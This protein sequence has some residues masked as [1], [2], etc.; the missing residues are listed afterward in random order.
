MVFSYF[1]LIAKV[2]FIG[3]IVK[4][5]RLRTTVVDLCMVVNLNFCLDRQI[6]CKELVLP[7]WVNYEYFSEK[8]IFSNFVG[9]VVHC[10]LGASECSGLQ[11]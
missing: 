4:H 11:L 5:S 9:V 8:I 1:L 6:F 3:Y 2:I 10:V 7:V